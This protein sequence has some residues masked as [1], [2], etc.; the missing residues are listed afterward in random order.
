MTY[1]ARNTVKNVTGT[2]KN[3]TRKYVYVSQSPD[4]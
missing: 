3:H 2:V 4:L 1:L